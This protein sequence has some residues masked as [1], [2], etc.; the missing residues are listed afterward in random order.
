MPQIFNAYLDGVSIFLLQEWLS[1]DVTDGALD[2]VTCLHGFLQVA[3]DVR[4]SLCLKLK[5]EIV[6]FELFVLLLGLA[7]LQLHLRDVI[8]RR[9]KGLLILGKVALNALHIGLN[10]PHLPI[11][12]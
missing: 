7:K 11:H 5:P 12:V 1:G 8:F 4:H 2:F 6:L 10:L 9:L 3:L